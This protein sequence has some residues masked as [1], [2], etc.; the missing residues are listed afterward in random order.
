MTNSFSSF[1]LDFQYGVDGEKLVSDLLLGRK[2]IEVKRD[3]KWI[4]T[5]NIYIETEC[6]F[7]KTNSW[8][9]SGLSVTKAGYWA[10]VIED[11]IVIVPTDVLR[12][13][14]SVYGKEISCHIPPNL[15]KGFLI[16]PEQLISATKEYPRD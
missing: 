12:F 15:S 11:S 4:K 3:R 10:F 14:V 8:E 1:D 2:T 6:F 13:A 16:T 9:M 7:T 5:G